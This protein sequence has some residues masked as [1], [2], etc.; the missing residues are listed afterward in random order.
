MLG[1]FLLG[2][3][4]RDRI[5]CTRGRCV[6][7]SETGSYDTFF[8][9]PSTDADDLVCCVYVFRAVFHG[10]AEPIRSRE[11]R[12]MLGLI[13]GFDLYRRPRWRTID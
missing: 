1:T 4:Q 6:A 2:S 8:S 3:L 12:A 10:R 11:G 7:G 13:F 9:T 5:R